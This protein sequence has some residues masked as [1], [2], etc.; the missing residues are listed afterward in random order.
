[1]KR[2]FRIATALMPEVGYWVEFSRIDEETLEVMVR[3]PDGEPPLQLLSQGIGSVIGWT[4][5]LI[6]R[7]E[8]MET[9]WWSTRDIQ[10]IVLVDEIDA[11]LHP[12]WQRKIVRAIRNEFPAVQVIATTHSP[13][14]LGI[15]PTHDCCTCGG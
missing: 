11:H 6:A 12:K 9:A 7:L 5:T 10:G 1:M 14:L 15:S 2:F 3:T 8:D 4:G 13:L